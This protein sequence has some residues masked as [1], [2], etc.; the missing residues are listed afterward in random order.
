MDNFLKE[1]D[2]KELRNT[3]RSENQ[4]QITL[5]KIRHSEMKPKYPIKYLTSTLAVLTLAIILFLPSLFNTMEQTDNSLSV[6]Q[7]LE[8]LKFEV[9]IG[10]ST[11]EVEVI[12]GENYHV[13]NS[14]YDGST[15]WQYDIG[16]T[17]E[18]QTVVDYDFTNL[19]GMQ[20]GLIKMQV[21]ITW[22]DS[23]L[24]KNWSA[25][26]LNEAD[27]KIYEYILLPNGEIKEQSILSIE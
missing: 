15:L 24:V 17:K 19:E 14:S 4:K 16:T 13:T 11:E 6:N 7:V 12:M 8:L 20:Q 10:M 23:N 3:P 2:F 18:Y 21:F 26:Y 25:V 22:D 1:I 5:N 27:N 9:K